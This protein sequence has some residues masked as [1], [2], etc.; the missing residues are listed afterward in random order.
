METLDAL[1]NILLVLN[2]NHFAAAVLIALAAIINRPPPK[3]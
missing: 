2:T 1:T 3:D